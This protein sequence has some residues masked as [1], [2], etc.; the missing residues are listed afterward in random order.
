MEAEDR[1]GDAT[2]DHQWRGEKRYWNDTPIA[3]SGLY[4]TTALT[5]ENLTIAADGH[6]ATLEVSDLP[7]IDE[8]AFP[9]AG[10][11]HPAL[12]SYRLIWRATGPLRAYAD[13]TK[14]F[15]IHGYPATVE[16]QVAV[17]VP[18]LGFTFTGR[19]TATVVAILGSEVNGYFADHGQQPPV[20]TALP[21]LPALGEAGGS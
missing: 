13:P 9:K 15:L 1:S 7:V 18:S 16:A 2:I 4:W 19:A 17:A 12:A 14:H 20:G 21:S 3:P 11:S 8:P 5:G 6:A 10:P